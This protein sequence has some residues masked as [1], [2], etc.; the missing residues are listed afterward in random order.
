MMP[1]FKSHSQSRIS[2]QARL[3]NFGCCGL[4]AVQSGGNG[5]PV[6]AIKAKQSGKI[7][8]R[9]HCTWLIQIHCEL[10]IAN[11]AAAAL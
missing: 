6:S 2:F 9:H 3:P 7:I 4:S 11:A 5:M 1:N 10:L 8:V